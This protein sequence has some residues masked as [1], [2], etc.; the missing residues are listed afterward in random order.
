MGKLLQ[1]IGVDRKGLKKGFWILFL[2]ALCT[3]ALW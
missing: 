1:I 2:T 3:I